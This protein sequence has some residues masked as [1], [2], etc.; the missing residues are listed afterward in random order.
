MLVLFV[1][2]F[3]PILLSGENPLV[4]F[5]IALILHRSEQILRIYMNMLKSWGMAPSRTL[6]T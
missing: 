5:G 3:F 1:I 6:M 2:F 4:D